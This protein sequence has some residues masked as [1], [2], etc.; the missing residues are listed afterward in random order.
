[1]AVLAVAILSSVTEKASFELKSQIYAG[2][3]AIESIYVEKN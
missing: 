1:M 2:A 3:V